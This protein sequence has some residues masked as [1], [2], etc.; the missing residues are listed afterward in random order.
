[1]KEAFLPKIVRHRQ[2]DVLPTINDVLPTIS[3]RKRGYKFKKGRIL[4]R[5]NNNTIEVDKRD[6]CSCTNQ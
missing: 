4:F 3:E 6:Q 1:M 2:N 5:T